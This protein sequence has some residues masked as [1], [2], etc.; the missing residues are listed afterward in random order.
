MS[1]GTARLQT[2][3]VSLVMPNRNNE[4]VLEVVLQRLAYNT[5]YPDVELI[6]VDD[7]S[8]DGSLEIL[9]RWR[10]TGRFGG[11]FEL[12]EREHRGVVAALNDGLEA[13]TGEFVVQL[14]ADASIETGS[15]IERMLGFIRSDDR[16]GVVTAK[17]VLDSGLLH[18]AGVTL[19]SEAGLHDRGTTIDEPVGRRTIH[20]RVQRPREG[21]SPLEDRIAEVD[22]GIGCAMMYRRDVALAIG[23]YDPGFHPVWFDD[24]DLCIAFRARGYKVFY[25]PEVRVLHR[26][27]E[28]APSRAEAPPPL[29]ARALGRL[30]RG[31][32]AMVPGAWR[33]PIARRIGLDRPDAPQLER[34]AHHRAHWSQKWG[35]DLLNPDMEAVR[36]RYGGTEVCWAAEPD[37]RR[38]GEEIIEAYQRSRAERE[39]AGEAEAGLRYLDRHG[40]LPPPSW[41]TMAQYD[42]LLDAFEERGLHR[43]GGDVVEIGVLLGGGTYQL[44]RLLERL[45]P[46]RRVFAVDVFD[47]DVDQV[48][49]GF[50]PTMAQIYRSLLAGREQLDVY[51]A[52]VAGCAN[53]VTLVGD[54]AEVELPTDAVAFA[55]IDGNHTPEYVRGDFERVWSRTLPGGVVA[56]DDYGHDLPQV[57]ATIDALREEHAGEVESFWTAGL[58]TAFLQRRA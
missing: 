44:A 19:V 1:A 56:L 24:L 37:R 50:G 35:W 39:A 28:R 43:L 25:L 29:R 5:T 26:V 32:G 53:V 52:V 14:D 22:S 47:P 6:V 13:A 10:E 16:I 36:A 20:T 30:R 49:S 17:V 3:R 58:K 42:H 57:T 18:T 45:A 11:D 9:R 4:A 51:R 31:A 41:A 40:F 15:W 7:G 54:S 8:S 34:L 27:W 2:P 23:G 48:A 46:E 33:E 38:A 12:L 21:E 55:H